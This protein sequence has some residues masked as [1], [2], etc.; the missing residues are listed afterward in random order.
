M[1]PIVAVRHCPA[2]PRP[3]GGTTGQSAVITKEDGTGPGTAGGTAARNALER[4]QIAWDRARDGQRDNARIERLPLSRRAV[5][6][7]VVSET[8][9]RAVLMPVPAIQPF[10]LA[11]LPAAPCSACGQG[12]WWRVSVLSGGPGPWTC[13]RCDPAPP[14]VWQDATAYP[15]SQTG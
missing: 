13:V 7:G 12:A 6:P 5:A 15:T 3:G 2:V 4:L 8:A 14:E 9:F 11:H 1:E 10:D